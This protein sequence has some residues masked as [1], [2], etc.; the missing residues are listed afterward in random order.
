MSTGRAS[1]APQ[2]ERV[3]EPRKATTLR[4]GI[5]EPVMTNNCS[6]SVARPVSIITAF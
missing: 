3:L 5:T 6:D 1:H 4:V 2:T